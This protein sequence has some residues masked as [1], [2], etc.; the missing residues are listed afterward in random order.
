MVFEVAALLTPS[1]NENAEVRL[2]TSF[3][4]VRIHLALPI[5]S[6]FCRLTAYISIS[7]NKYL[8]IF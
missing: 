2:N 7:G 1:K 4:A 5:R 8:I 3:Q 6:D